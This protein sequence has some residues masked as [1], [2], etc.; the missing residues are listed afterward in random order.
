MLT[1]R[2]Q[3]RLCSQTRPWLSKSISFKWAYVNME[4][5]WLHTQRCTRLCLSG[6]KV[7]VPPL[8]G[9]FVDTY[10]KSRGSH[11]YCRNHMRPG[12]SQRFKLCYMYVRDI[13]VKNRLIIQQQS[14]ESKV[15]WKLSP[16]VMSL[17]PQSALCT[18]VL[19]WHSTP[20]L[21]EKH[22]GHTHI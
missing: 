11:M 2:W 16:G 17:Q 14:P 4:F 7:Y 21:G 22:S 19:Q 20:A 5:G 15:E 12:K 3:R 9:S 18:K 10:N 13:L 8:L 1:N 6:L